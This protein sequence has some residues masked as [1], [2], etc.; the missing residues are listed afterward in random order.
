GDYSKAALG[1]PDS[2]LGRFECRKSVSAGTACTG[3]GAGR[4]SDGHGRFVSGLGWRLVEPNALKREHRPV[5]FSPKQDLSNRF[6]MRGMPL[7]LLRYRVDI[8]KPPLER[9]AVEDRQRPGRRVK[10]RH[11]LAR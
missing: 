7:N 1:R 6:Q 4:A 8:T 2:V 10:L 3:S 11:G 5:R 9:P